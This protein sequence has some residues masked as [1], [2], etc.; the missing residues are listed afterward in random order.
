MFSAGFAIASTALL[1]LIIVVTVVYWLIGGVPYVPTPKFV[2]RAM[3]DL[4]RFSGS[5][6]VIDIGAGNGRLL[7]EAKRKHPSIEATG[8]EISPTVWLLGLLTVLASGQKV[9]LSLGN[10]LNCHMGGADVIFLYLSP[11]F[12]KTLEE[13]FDREL[14]PGTVVISHAFSF[15]RRQPTEIA[16]LPHWSGK[17]TIRRYEW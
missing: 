2:A 17:K 1:I 15:P 7:V 6:K 11:A 12:M 9:R 16:A 13:K 3:V 5:E 4:A 8:V 14:R 10:A